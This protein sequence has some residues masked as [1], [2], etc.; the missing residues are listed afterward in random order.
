LEYILKAKE[1]NRKRKVIE[2]SPIRRTISLMHIIEEL[3]REIKDSN[4]LIQKNWG[5]FLIDFK[6]ESKS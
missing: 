2:R 4:D 3:G 5:W 6:S 1:L